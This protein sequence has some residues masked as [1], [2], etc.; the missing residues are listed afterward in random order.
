PATAATT[1]R[2]AQTAHPAR[3]PSPSSASRRNAAA[4]G[5]KLGRARRDVPTCSHDDVL[6]RHSRALRAAEPLDVAGWNRAQLKSSVDRAGYL[7]QPGAP[8]MQLEGGEE[9]HACTRLWI[10]LSR[11]QGDGCDV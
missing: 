3:S 8:H 11:N 6:P 5:C 2:R 1:A 9:A 4:D 10:F 7:A